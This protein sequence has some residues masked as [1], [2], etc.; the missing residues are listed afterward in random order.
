MSMMDF[1]RWVWEERL[2]MVLLAAVP[3]LLIFGLFVKLHS[4]AGTADVEGDHPAA[5]SHPR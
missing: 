4:H 3:L 1:L 5:P 2:W